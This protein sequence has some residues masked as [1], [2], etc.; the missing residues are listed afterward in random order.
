MDNAT[1]TP[2]PVRIDDLE[3]YITELRKNKADTV[4]ISVEYPRQAI[5]KDGKPATYLAGIIK[6]TAFLNNRIYTHPQKVSEGVVETDEQAA[7]IQ[8]TTEEQ[9]AYIVKEFQKSFSGCNIIKGAIGI[10]IF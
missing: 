7:A 2:I 4:F 8:K 5:Q 3:D 9:K 10:G 1:T 6:L